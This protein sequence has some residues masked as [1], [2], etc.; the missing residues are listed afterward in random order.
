MSKF[1]LVE[2]FQRGERNKMLWMDESGPCAAM[3]VPVLE[4]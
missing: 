4:E 3:M 2:N 1:H